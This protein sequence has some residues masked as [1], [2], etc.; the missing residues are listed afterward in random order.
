MKK[1]KLSLGFVAL[2]MAVAMVFAFTPVRHNEKAHQDAEW[3]HYNGG[4][5]N[6]P[7]NYEPGAGSG[8][9]GDGDL[10]SIRVE[11]DGEQPDATALSNMQDEITSAVNSAPTSNVTL[12]E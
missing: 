11:A 7:A 1:L 4:G 5:Y 12:K 8:C 2:I 6:N 9:S 10:C 3:F